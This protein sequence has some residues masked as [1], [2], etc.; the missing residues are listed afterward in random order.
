MSCIHGRLY[1]GVQKF[2]WENVE[3][4]DKVSCHQSKH[5]VK[6]KLRGK[7]RSISWVKAWF[8]H[9]PWLY[10]YIFFSVFFH[11]G[12]TIFFTEHGIFIYRR[13]IGKLAT[14]TLRNFN[15]TLHVSKE[16]PSDNS[17]HETLFIQKTF[18]RK[19]YSEMTFDWCISFIKIPPL[20]F[21]H[22]KNLVS[23]L[24]CVIY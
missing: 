4:T 15:I 14:Q 2:F 17:L 22:L 9:S 11:H 13:K 10:Y 23:S 21:P 5:Q 12:F 3:G 18:V 6:Q 24:L 7:E 19:F 16:P 1:E 20:T 8:K